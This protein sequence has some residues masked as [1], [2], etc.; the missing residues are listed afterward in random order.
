MDGKPGA[1]ASRPIRASRAF[2]EG[3]TANQ[4]FVGQVTTS[5]SPVAPALKKSEIERKDALA[6]LVDDKQAS[7]DADA[8]GAPPR[9]SGTEHAGTKSDGPK[10]LAAAKANPRLRPFTADELNRAS[11]C[12]SESLLIIGIEAL[13]AM[14]TEHGG[15]TATSAAP[16]PSKEALEPM[17]VIARFKEVDRAVLQKLADLGI[18]IEAK[19]SRAEVLILRVPRERLIDLALVECA[20]RVDPLEGEKT[21]IVSASQEAPKP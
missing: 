1:P 11:A 4:P 12:L 17:L 21:S 9:E 18:R 8:G 7:D 10:A 3:Q 6:E 13:A 5:P 14:E 2:G 15:A 20:I 19:T 16:A